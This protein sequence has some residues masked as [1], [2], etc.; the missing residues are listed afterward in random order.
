MISA[1]PSLANLSLQNPWPGLRAFTEEDS[2][3]FFGRERETAELLDLV[4][5]SPVVVLYGQSGL[6]KTSLLQAGL[7]P[8]LKRLDFFPIRMRIDHGDGVAPLADQVKAS[9]S[10]E[11]DRAKIKGP[12][13]TPGE[14]LWEYFHRDDVDFWGPRNRL[15]IPV[16]VL[17]QFEEVFTLGQRT[18]EA[19]KRV[20]DFSSELEALFEHRPPDAVRL[21]L[22]A[23][24]DEASQYNLRKQAVKF[25]IALRED[26]LA[27]LDPWRVRMPSLLPNRFRL[28]PMTGAQALDVVQRA[29]GALTDPDVAREIVDF[30]S[31]SR[32]RQT[33]RAMEHRDV[34][35]AILSVVCDELNRRRIELGQSKITGD[36]LSGEREEIIRSFY[37]RSFDG[38]DP[39]VRTWVED[40]LL[41]ASGYRDRAALEDALRQGLKEEDFDLLVDRRILHRE[42]R[43][44]VVWLELTHDLLTDPASE[45]RSLREQRRQAEAAKQQAED[46]RK[47]KEKYERDLRKSRILTAVFGV[48]LIVAALG[49][50]S[51][52][53]ARNKA[54]ASDVR[55]TKALANKAESDEAAATM[56][57]RQSRESIGIGGSWVPAETVFQGIRDTEQSYA[58]LAKHVASSSDQQIRLIQGHANYLAQAAEAYYRV[59]HYTD[60]LKEAR[61][62]LDL[63]KQLDASGT[64]TDSN[65]LL[66][67]QAIYEE[68]SGLLTL[69]QM[70]Q[71]KSDFEGAI[72]LTTSLSIP[73]MKLELSRVI[74]QSQ[75]GLGQIEVHALAYGQALPH[76][77][78]AIQRNDSIQSTNDIQASDETLSLK[79]DALIG[80]G[81]SQ[82]NEAEALTWY[83]KATNLLTKASDLT[84][85]RWRRIAAE[86]DYF[87]G[88][89][90]LR[91][92]KYD[93]A[94]KS[95]DQAIE[96]TEDLC[97]RDPENLLWQLDRL[98][99]MRGL[100][101]MHQYRGELDLSQQN[102]EKALEIAKNLNDNQP[103]WARAAYLRGILVMGL[104]DI[105]ER[106]Y[107]EAENSQK[108]TSA[109]SV[110]WS[111][112]PKDLVS[113]FD[114]YA[115]S[116]E[117]LEK[118][119]AADPG[120][121]DFI[122][123]VSYAMY[124]Q[125]G[126]RAMQAGA[127]PPG[128]KNDKA[129]QQRAQD[130]AKKLHQEALEFYSQALKELG[131]IE[132]GSGNESPEVLQDKANIYK[133]IGAV[134]LDLVDRQKA[135]SSYSEAIQTLKELVK[136]APSAENYRRLSL[137]QLSLGD[138][139]NGGKDISTASAQY[140]L[141]MDAIK[142]TLR[143]EPTDSGALNIESVIESRFADVMITQ[144]DPAGALDQ[145]EKASDTLWTALQSDYSDDLLNSNLD[146]YIK[147]LA[148]I[149]TALQDKRKAAASTAG[150]TSQQ[151]QMTT[152]QL[153]ALDKRVNAL[154]AKIEPTLLLAHYGQKPW[155]LPPLLPGAWRTLGGEELAGTLKQLS[156]FAKSLNLKQVRGMRRLP[157]DFYDDAALYELEV[158]AGP[159]HN[160]IVS[161]VQR[162]KDWT[163][164]DG[165]AER[166]QEMNRKSPPKLDTPE[167]AIEYLRFFMGAIQKPEQGTLV[168]IDQI[169]DILW[170]P[171]VPDS[172][173]NNAADLI[174]PLIVEESAD[175]EWQGIGTIEYGGFLYG[176]SFLLSR[177]GV[178]TIQ[179]AK[180]SGTKLPIYIGSYCDGIRIRTT[181]EALPNEKVQC[182]ISD[183]KQ[184][185]NA[186]PHDKKALSDL[187]ALYDKNQDVSSEVDVMKSWLALNPGDKDNHLQL[188]LL[189]ERSER[190][191]EA[192]EA[193]K[194]WLASA[195]NESEPIH[196]LPF[197]YAGLER[198]KDAAEAENNWIAYVQRD[199]KDEANRR[200]LLANAYL[201][202]SWYQL[203]TR[204]FAGAL[205]SADAGE[206]LK[207]NEADLHIDTNRAHAL[208]FIGRITDADAIYL[209]N[210][211]KKIAPNSDQTW[212][213][214]VLQDFDDLEK[215]GLTSPEFARLRKLLLPPKPLPPQQK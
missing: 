193:D 128:D 94:K 56:A 41:T 101:L 97:K 184:K 66:R 121:M 18:E 209:G 6:G 50:I 11:L 14:T 45:S 179:R 54:I 180:A 129:A 46:A 23:H 95:F 169:D 131:P 68:G 167:R 155:S 177:N 33:A 194:S 163:F 191:D 141:A 165:T 62:A 210:K 178:V 30:V 37:E 29:G 88:F 70:P 198:W 187:M 74:V 85:P 157:L 67:A 186:S 92:G 65:R 215:G 111:P 148:K 59:G 21:R 98:Q 103:S 96:V 26:F 211:G 61:S 181:M 110:S 8:G 140:T 132:K 19:S 64:P 202:L 34:E 20:A 190:W 189:Y 71:A 174:K 17:D 208:L 146:Y 175:H 112:D 90:Y 114:S 36:L 127:V 73:D 91:L 69:G 31:T 125:G 15:L 104:G 134:Q 115:G 126:L 16:I 124:E 200:I 120:Y 28:E 182:E 5:R 168:L 82:W 60:G 138:V 171:S 205:A 142:I 204:D 135:L 176:A 38:V 123:F 170:L 158:T 152:A 89:S 145:L 49:G 87:E 79:I 106:K 108:N 35:P 122:R 48:L 212:N 154:D 99:A 196:Q 149:R 40:E 173:R 183:A 116:R 52:Y 213:E 153:D 3:F 75:I 156:T 137:A 185:L 4:Q 63:V 24:P 2:G 39:R 55:A 12:R 161:Y 139:Y 119:A 195:P 136:K 151:N 10:A 42:E 57:E 113:A 164:L 214:V 172:Q 105:L 162:G 78:D 201:G 107:S 44:G 130:A 72:Q 109:T 13:P 166:I 27:D 150:A 53:I 93:D 133:A 206:K 143:D 25:V 81:S 117:I 9:I 197:V 86:I 80:I 188:I 84:T 83:G 159:N 22:E 47:Q 100:G 118:A 58:D 76:F 43:S 77:N 192:L 7:F 102:L 160:G 207:A 203:F 144:G 51:A 32:R 199:V 1:I 147:L